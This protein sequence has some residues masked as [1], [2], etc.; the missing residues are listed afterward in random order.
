MARYLARL[1][2]D[3]MKGMYKPKFTITPEINSR[4][5]EIERIRAQIERTSILPEVE[6]HLRFRATIE[7]V[8]S[9]TSIEGNPLNELQVKEVLS[10]KVIRAPDHAIIEVINYKKALDWIS[11]QQNKPL[12]TREILSVH[13]LMMNDLLPSEKV[14][15]FRP[16][17]IYVVNQENEN[18]SIE[19]VGPEA[20]EVPRLVE[21]LCKWVGLEQQTILHPVLRAGYISLFVCFNSPI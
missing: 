20:Y 14:G 13:Q 9:S 19:Y 6:V 17:P 7:S 2:R 16:G 10:G 15:H 5:A 8:H 18:E 1:W 21:S 3:I 4:I 11:R 12:T